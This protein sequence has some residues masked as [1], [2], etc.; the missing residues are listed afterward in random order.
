MIPYTPA[1]HLRG[2]APDGTQRPLMPLS[3]HRTL[4]PLSGALSCR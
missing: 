4:L 2:S 1:T 3:A